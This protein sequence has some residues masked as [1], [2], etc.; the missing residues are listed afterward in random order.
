MSR[1]VLMHDPACPDFHDHE[2]VEDPERGRDHDKE[3]A[4]YDALCVIP[5]ERRPTLLRIRR[6]SAL[7]QIQGKA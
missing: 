3:V 5:D 1:D 7:V 4:G 6:A 2:Y